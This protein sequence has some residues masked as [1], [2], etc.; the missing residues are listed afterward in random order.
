MFSSLWLQR[1]ISLLG[2]IKSE[3]TDPMRQVLFEKGTLISRL[4]F[5]KRPGKPPQQWLSTTYADAYQTLNQLHPFDMD[6][7]KSMIHTRKSSPKSRGLSPCPAN[8]L[9][10]NVIFHMWPLLPSNFNHVSYT[11]GLTNELQG[12]DSLSPYACLQD[13]ALSR[14]WPALVKRDDDDDDDDDE[15]DDDDDDDGDEVRSHIETRSKMSLM[16]RGQISA[17]RKA[18]A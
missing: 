10:C 1:K 16:S 2:L 15:D 12:I 13:S 7:P 3:P 5:R 14:L 17:R 11:L 6:N 9:H 4:E 18:R 8:M